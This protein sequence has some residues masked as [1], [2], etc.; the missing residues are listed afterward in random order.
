MLMIGV[1]SSIEMGGSHILPNSSNIPNDQGNFNGDY[2]FDYSWENST[3]DQWN[4]TDN[5]EY[6]DYFLINDGTDDIWVRILTE[7]NV[8]TSYSGDIQYFTFKIFEDPDN[9]VLKNWEDNWTEFESVDWQGYQNYYW[10]SYSE[11]WSEYIGLF[12]EEHEEYGSEGQDLIETTEWGAMWSEDDQY[13]DYTYAYDIMHE[14]LT[15]DESW[16]FLNIYF[17]DWDDY[18][19]GTVNYTWYNDNTGELFDPNSIDL[20]PVEG[21][22]YDWEITQTML[23]NDTFD[24]NYSWTW[25]SYDLSQWVS[26]FDVVSDSTNFITTDTSYTGMSIYNDLNE[27]GIADV[28]YDYDE[29]FGDI[30][31]DLSQSEIEYFINMGS[32]ENIEFGINSEQDSE[33]LN[34]WVNLEGVNLTTLPYGYGYD[35]FF[36][37]DEYYS[38]QESQFYLNNM[39]LSFSYEPQEISDEE[40]Q[41][42]SSNFSIKHDLS[43]FLYSN[44][45]S[46][47]LSEFEGM[48]LTID[49]SVS[50]DAFSSIVGID[51]TANSYEFESYKVDGGVNVQTEDSTLMSMNLSQ[52]YKWGKDG[53]DYNNTVTLSPIYGF[54]LNYGNVEMGVASIYNGQSASYSYSLCFGNW[55][56]YSISMDPTFT[57]FYT[58]KPPIRF[59]IYL[60]YVIIH[61][62]VLFGIIMSK[63]EYRTFLLNRVLQIE[64]GAHRLTMEDVLENENR[65]KVID[66]IVDNPGIHFSELLR[67][68]QLAPGNLNWHIGILE[69]YKIIKNEIIG[70]YVMYFTYHGKNPLSN[71]DLKL[72]KSKTTMDILQIIQTTPGLAQNQI[73]K[74]I[75][76]N[77]KTVKY[78]LDK[79]I[80]AELIEKRIQGRRKLLFPT[81]DN[82]KDFQ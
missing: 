33:N 58:F 66:L 47:A 39:N 44:N 61:L 37:E 71:I 26:W 3:L 50:S 12:W 62:A 13:K 40:T 81:I 64:T 28:F 19:L 63:Q 25:F 16:W 76:R 41:V 1:T 35:L 32:I 51:E 59:P 56:G 36:Y 6:E 27:N 8:T 46:S 65:S 77:H 14:S 78:H 53:Q 4:L 10:D 52:N 67:Q 9:S 7:K 45:H 30:S 31:Y 60:L 29:E 5:S 15:G 48:G 57:S 49:Y 69:R 55:E 72:Q 38:E 42:N 2:Y 80:E 18:Y 43:E 82:Q 73:A 23:T 17:E 34:F 79:L 75:E 21:Y 54:D 11:G 74:Q 24:D 70:K 68:T 22:E 20:E